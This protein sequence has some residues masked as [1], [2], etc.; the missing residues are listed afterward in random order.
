MGSPA[1]LFQNRKSYSLR[2]FLRG[3]EKTLELAVDSQSGQ[4]IYR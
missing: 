2:H 1:T 3:K 4:D